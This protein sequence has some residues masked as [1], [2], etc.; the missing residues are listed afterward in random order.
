MEGDKKVE[1]PSFFFGGGVK[2]PSSTF[3]LNGLYNG[4]NTLEQ[5]LGKVLRVRVHTAQSLLQYKMLFGTF[6]ASSL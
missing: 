4:F 3:P 5:R 1:I 6:L 2:I